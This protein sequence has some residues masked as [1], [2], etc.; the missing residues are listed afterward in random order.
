MPLLQDDEQYLK[1]K[2]YEFQTLDEASRTLLIIKQF[3]LP[4]G[5]S[6]DAVDLL[7]IIPQGYPAAALD[8]FWV[9]PEVRIA[10]NNSYPVNADV[11]ETFLGQ[12]WQRFSRHYSWRPYVDSVA[13]HLNSVQRSLMQIA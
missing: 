13:S 6:Q 8:M 2:G 3:K 5:Y 4:I 7:I 11:F 10:S 12:T 1:N 9:I